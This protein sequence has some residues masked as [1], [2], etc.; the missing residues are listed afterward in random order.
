MR[1]IVLDT[2][3][4]GL[5]FQSGH[6]IVEIGCV[7]LW[8]YL[9]TGNTFQSYINPRRSMDPGATRV[10]GI[11]DAMLVDKPT[12]DEIAKSFLDFIQNDP[13]V[14][15]NAPFDMGFLNGELGLLKYI[16]I[17]GARAID[18]VV[19]ARK[20]FP[21]SPANLDALCRRFEIDLSARTKH[22]ALLDA[23]LLAEVYLHLNGGRQPDLELANALAAQSVMPIQKR[24]IR[25]SRIFPVASCDLQK[26]E[27]FLKT[28]K[29]PLW[30]KS[31]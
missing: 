6:R 19:M 4:T 31:A 27:A 17:D 7:E 10:S 5:S 22:G 18:T 26:H 9:P 24:T 28:I 1:H 21:G 25:P 2:E 12:F 20:L 11:T 3:T 30:D 29:E 15:H 8:N 16:P 13:L 23:Q 14:I